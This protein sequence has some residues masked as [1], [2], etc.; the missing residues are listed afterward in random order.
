MEKIWN[1]LE[2]F[3]NA[4]VENLAFLGVCLL[5]FLLVFF[6]A[7]GFER[8]NRRRSGAAPQAISRPRYIAV[9]GMCAATA[10]LLMFL[11]VPLFFAPSFYKLDFSE[12]PVLVCAFA[13]GPTAG[14]LCEFLKVLLKLLF[15]GTTTAFVGDFS[16]FI[17]GCTLVLPASMLYCWRKTKKRAAVGLL[18]G[19]L[20]MTIFGSALNAFYLIPQYVRL[21]GLPLETIIGMGAAVNSAINSVSTLVLFA[22][23]PFNLLKGA[24]VSI[25]TLLIY[26]H[27]KPILIRS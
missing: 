12:I 21:F 16:N 23:V 8:L 2:K 19:T 13:M 27:I 4:I 18:L 20:C 10:A 11:E 26:K 9:L 25:I 7:W 6:L 14:V 1:A 15:K 3:W 22:V 5:V 24:A 17:I